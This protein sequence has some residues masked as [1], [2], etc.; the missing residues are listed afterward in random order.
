MLEP[1]LFCQGL[2]LGGDKACVDIPKG[3]SSIGLV[4]EIEVDSSQDV[5]VYSWVNLGVSDSSEDLE[6]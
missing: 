6:A 4:Q 2:N 3:M 5:K 1:N